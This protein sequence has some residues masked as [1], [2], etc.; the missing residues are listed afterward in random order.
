MVFLPK[1]TTS[2]L[3]PAHVGIIRNLKAKRRKYLARHVAS[4]LNRENTASTIIKQVIVLDAIKWLKASWDEVNES[5]IRNCFK[6]CGFSQVESVT[7]EAQDDAEFQ[8]LFQFLTTKVITEEEYLSFDDDF[9]IHKKQ[10]NTTQ[11]D[12]WERCIQEVTNDVV[13]NQMELDY[14]GSD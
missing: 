12:W 6:K 10:N 5:A 14:E 2:K 3:H 11:F 7:E 4:L 8:D 9:E 13:E 1:N